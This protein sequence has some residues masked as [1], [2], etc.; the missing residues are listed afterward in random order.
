MDKIIK[1]KRCGKILAQGL[2]QSILRK[3]G[4][5]PTYNILIT[6][7]SGGDLRRQHDNL[8]LCAFCKTDFDDFMK[9]RKQ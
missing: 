4:Q 1:C 5:M 8:N 9:E 7:F 3:E 6:K 2:G